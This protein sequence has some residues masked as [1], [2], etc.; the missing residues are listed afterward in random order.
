MRVT[1]SHNKTRQEVKKIVDDSADQMFRG[2]PGSPVQIQDQQ[3]NWNGDVMDFSL[4]GKMG[5]FS[6]PLKGTVSVTDKDVTVDCEL[7]GIL[8]SF[9]PE[10]KVKASIESQVRGLLNAP[11]TPTR[12]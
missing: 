12:S 2:M 7:P 11:T 8:K 10:E 9:M 3:K 6:A 1:V 5:I 4:T